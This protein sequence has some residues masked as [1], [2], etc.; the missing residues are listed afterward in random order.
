VYEETLRQPMIELVR[1][2]HGEMMSFAPQYVG[3]PAKCVFRIY[4]DTR[5]SKNKTPY[6]THVAAS[7]WRSGLEKT[8]SGFYLGIS[9]DGI[10]VDGGLYAPEPEV[11]RAVRQAIADDPEGFRKTYDS[12]KVRKLVG[13][14]GGESMIRPPKGFDPA[15]PAIELLK[16]KQHVFMVKLD[17]EVAMTPKLLSEVTKRFAAMTPTIE[18][19]DRALLTEGKAAKQRF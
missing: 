18:F 11:L 3:E 19:L 16:R 2:I 4:R 12:A 1:A 9:P 13:E 8:G 17:A 15:H 10:D 5:F 14:P 6:K 7:F